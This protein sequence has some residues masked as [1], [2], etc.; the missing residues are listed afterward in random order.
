MGI[1]LV[2]TWEKHA[3]SSELEF[4][5]SQEFYELFRFYSRC[6]NKED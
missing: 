3:A 5:F 6:R 1:Y 2:V 4:D